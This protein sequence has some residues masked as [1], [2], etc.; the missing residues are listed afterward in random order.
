LAEIGGFRADSRS[1]MTKLIAQPV[2]AI[3]LRLPTSDGT[4]RMCRASRRTTEREA[5]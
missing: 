4:Y 1:L 2:D 5:G 3:H